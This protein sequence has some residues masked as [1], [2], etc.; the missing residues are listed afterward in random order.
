MTKRLLLNL[1]GGAGG[2][3]DIWP[4]PRSFSSSCRYLLRSDFEA[5]RADWC[6]VG[7]DLREALREAESEIIHGEPETE[8]QAE[9]SAPDPEG[10]DSGSTP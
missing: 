9:E 3:L 8:T 4:K 5:L 10:R 6:E 2:V 7:E 1:V